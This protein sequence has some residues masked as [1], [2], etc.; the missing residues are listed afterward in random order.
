L[1]RASDGAIDEYIETTALH[2]SETCCGKSK[3]ESTYDRVEKKK[4]R[5][6]E[7]ASRRC[8]KSA[9]LSRAE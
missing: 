5:L 3:H 6:R 8:Q 2:E 9:A 4:R 1:R 7:N